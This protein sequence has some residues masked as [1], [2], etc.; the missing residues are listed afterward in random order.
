MSDCVIY[1]RQSLARHGDEL[2]IDRQLRECRRVAKARGLHVRDVLTDNNY[3]ASKRGRPAYERLTQMMASGEVATVIILRI[4]RLLRLNDELEELIQ[5]VEQHPVR[6][7]TAEGD[8]DL[9]TPQGRLIARIL[10]SVARS[11]MEVKSERHKLANRQRAEAGKPHGSRR[12]YGYNDDYRT[13]HPV[14][15]PILSKMGQMVIDGVSFRHVAY[16][17]NE[18][19]YTTTEGKA[20]YPIT[21]RNMLSKARYGGYRTYKGEVVAEGDWEP[22]FDR[23]TWQLLQMTMRRRKQSGMPT[24]RKYLLTGHVFCGKCGQPLNGET[25]RDHPTRP[26]RPT[27]QCRVQGD[28]S[29]HKGC[30]GVCRNAEALD[31]WVRQCIVY[32]LDSPTLSKLLSAGRDDDRLHELLTERETLCRRKESLVDMLALGEL[33]RQ[34]YN[35]AVAN[36]EAALTAVDA[37][38]GQLT[39]QSLGSA[40]QAGESIAESWTTKDNRWRRA[41]IETLIERID[42]QP[43]RTKP[44]FTLPDGR[45]ARFDPTL[46]DIT[47]RA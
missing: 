1:R 6:V 12:P 22:V 8:V 46:I 5:L 38:V 30:G 3:S 26:L 20:W 27:Y 41:L 17:L 35:R 43:G 21:V 34:A 13:L 45:V 9:T 29:R 37:Q 25:K 19:G 36:V 11:E 23:D 33:D 40:L 15:A 28:T 31:E 44:F 4:D 32:R 24:A 16:W 39:A 2:G 42:V 14:E 47:W 10:V 7:I 18:Q